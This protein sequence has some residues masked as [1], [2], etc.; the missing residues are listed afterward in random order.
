M[1]LRALRLRMLKRVFSP[2]EVCVGAGSLERLGGLEPARVLLVAGASAR[3]HGMIERV[4]GFLKDATALEVLEIGGH[5]PKAENI[6]SM[7]QQVADFN[8][9]WIV[10]IGGGTVIDSA[11]FIW[12]QFEQPELSFGAK[13]AAIGNLRAKA[14]F[15]AIPTTAGSGS[16]ASQAAVLSTEDGTKTAYVSPQWL[17][18]VAILDPALSVSLPRGTTLAT[19]FDALT[20]A[21][22]SAV[23]TLGNGLLLALAA[24]AV[25][26]ILR[27]LPTVAEQPQDLAAREAMLEASYL[28]GL[29]Q[30]TTSTGVAHA[31]SHATS[32]LHGVSHGAA[33]S[34]Y[35][36]P[37]MRL[38]RAKNPKLYDGLATGC[39]YADGA[40]LTTAIAE[41][42]AAVGMPQRITELVGR[43]PEPG[44]L[45]ALATAS[46]QD[47]C[48]RTNACRLGA[49]EL[50]QLLAEIR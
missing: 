36:V 15:I 46:S 14:R 24:T 29:C 1:D 11:K 6:V 9:E 19:G 44:E 42:A 37:T 34:F 10:A 38:N 41:L 40:A 31:L 30:S 26:M 23:S 35:L 13:A 45:E 25:R 33:T 7:K 4:N 3:R 8:P 21:V 17:P 48:I 27:N 2:S 49:P 22:E 5:E 32:K 39:G 28:A 47:I 18:D 50:T 16:E 12:A 20:H 43:T